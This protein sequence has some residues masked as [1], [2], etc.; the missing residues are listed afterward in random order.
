MYLL[1]VGGDW[2]MVKNIMR[3]VTFF[4]V[5]FLIAFGGIAEAKNY[6]CSKKAGGVSHCSADGRYVCK[7]GRISKSKRKCSGG[8][9]SSIIDPLLNKIG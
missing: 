2:E 6:P 1:K 9:R 4:L 5:T 8:K 3:A 7:D